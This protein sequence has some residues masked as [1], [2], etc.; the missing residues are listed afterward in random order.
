MLGIHFRPPDR[1]RHDGSGIRGEVR[2]ATSCHEPVVM[3]GRHQHE[4]AP[5]LLHD[6]NGFALSPTLKFAE[7]P[8]K[9]QGS[10]S[11]HEILLKDHGLP[12]L[13]L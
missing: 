2:S 3:I 7:F 1:I 9:L 4:F 8:L 6:I 10:G 13:P 5:P 12:E 11:S